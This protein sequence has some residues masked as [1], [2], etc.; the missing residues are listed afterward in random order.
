[1]VKEN[2]SKIVD[3]IFCISL[4]DRKDRRKKIKKHMKT[5]KISF[6]F[7]NAIKNT[8]YPEKGC[9]Q[10]HLNIIKLAK[11][12][13]LK[14]ILIIEDDCIFIK[15]PILDLPPTDWDM[16]YLGGNVKM[17]A[18]RYSDNLFHVTEGV[19]CTHAILYSK[20]GIEI[21]LKNYDVFTNEIKSH[22]HWLFCVGQKIMECFICSPVIAY[23]R[24]GFSHPRNGYMDY[25][26]E[27]KENE[28]KHLI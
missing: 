28:K 22:D 3:S 27:M 17:P 18:K 21:T 26:S 5:R 9:L 20:K 6:K 23:Q 11:K 15:K 10:S 14:S 25:Y 1:M 7:Y 16:L 4:T 13:N 2:I 19:H 8:E 12:A 24:P